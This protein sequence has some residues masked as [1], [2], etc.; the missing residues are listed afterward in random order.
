MGLDGVELVMDIEDRFET[1]VPDIETEM[2]ET[3]GALHELLWERIRR[4]E[5]KTIW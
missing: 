2:M 5:S 3:V 1:N 4:R